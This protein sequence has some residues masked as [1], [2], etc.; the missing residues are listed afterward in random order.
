MKKTVMLLAPLVALLA[1]AARLQAQADAGA[2]SP[3]KIPGDPLIYFYNPRLDTLGQNL[4]KAAGGVAAGQIFDSQLSN[5]DAMAKLAADR[6]FSSAAG[7]ARQARSRARLGNPLPVCGSGQEKGSAFEA[8]DRG[9][10]EA[11][12]TFEDPG[13]RR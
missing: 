2:S 11:D 4:E 1:G 5:L 12:R 8:G 6:I 3:P 10:A 9:L 7:G 13:G